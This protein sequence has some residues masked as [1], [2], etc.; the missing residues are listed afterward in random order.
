MSG[1]TV[2]A[3]ALSEE[4]EEGQAQKYQQRIASALAMVA[5][6]SHS[7]DLCR[8]RAFKSSIKEEYKALCT[9][10]YAVDGM[11]F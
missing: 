9:D 2:L 10:D 4:D 8:Q 11:L 3:R 7:L 6:A 1:L 5:D